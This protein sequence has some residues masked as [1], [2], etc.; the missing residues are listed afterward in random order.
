MNTPI[1]LSDL[2]FVK[3]PSINYIGFHNGKHPYE[4]IKELIYDGDQHL[5]TIA[6]TGKGKGRSVI[7]PTLLKQTCPVFVIDPKGENYLVTARRRREMG[8]RVVLLD[9]FGIVKTTE[10]DS[11]NPLDICKL[12]CEDI[13]TECE[14]I[15]DNLALQ[16]SCNETYWDDNAKS[17]LSA[18][19]GYIWYKKP[20][21]K[22]TL[23]EVFR[24]FFE[25]DFEYRLA[26]ILDTDK[27]IPKTIYDAFAMYLQI[28]S[29]KT[30]P[31]VDSTFT[32]YINV[33]KSKGVLKSLGNSTFNI[34]DIVEGK[35]IDIFLVFPPDK[36]KSHQRLLILWVLTLIRAITA[37]TVIPKEPTLFILDE[38]AALGE[39]RQLESFITLC[40][41]YGARVWTFWQ[42]LAQLQ[43]NYPKSYS[44]FINNSGVIQIFGIDKYKAATDLQSLTGI[45]YRNIRYLEEDT[46]LLIIGKDEFIGVPKMDYLLHK[47]FK[48]LFEPNPIYALWQKMEMKEIGKTKKKCRNEKS[49]P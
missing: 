40:R 43:S 20:E 44:T 5:I 48:G 34:M 2:A 31:C 25:A 23:N 11:F 7:I 14:M 35:P 37:R 21:D 9:P 4:K 30:R 27:N 13:Y 41:G 3:N 42:D 22:R 17:L 6:P 47:E 33:M 39:F 28:P 36:L 8:H 32:T 24:F 49:C 16:G 45:N 38:T 26:V 18:L 12:P 15:A 19:I 1:K 10:A 46:Q 29:D